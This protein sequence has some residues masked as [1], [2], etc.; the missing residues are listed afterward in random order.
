MAE[1]TCPYCLRFDGMAAARAEGAR[2]CPGCG[3]EWDAPALEQVDEERVVLPGAR[4]T[5]AAAPAVSAAPAPGPPWWATAGAVLALLGAGLGGVLLYGH[6]SSTAPPASVAVAPPPSVAEAPVAAVAPPPSAAE[7]PAAAAR[8]HV[9][10]EGESLYLLASR[11]YG[12]GTQWKRI[13]E[14]NARPDPMRIGIGRALLIPPA[15]GGQA[16]V[17]AGSR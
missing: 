14:A 6:L 1:D 7:A 8:E 16:T 5:P 12:N 15:A 11:Y 3:A 10:L 17:M 9:V 4:A 13:W 2:Y